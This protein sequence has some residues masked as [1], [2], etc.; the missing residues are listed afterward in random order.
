V[1]GGCEEEARHRKLS[2]YV[3]MVPSSDEP[4]HVA[5]VNEGSSEVLMRE[6][7]KVS[8]RGLVL[9]SWELFSFIVTLLAYPTG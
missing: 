7:K 3:M 5:L 1:E 9:G 2:I 4:E 6:D 8:V